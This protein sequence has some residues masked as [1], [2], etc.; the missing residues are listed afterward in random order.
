[1]LLFDFSIT[2]QAQIRRLIYGLVVPRPIAWVS[3]QSSMGID[4]LAPHSFYN[5]VSAA[6][7]ILM[8][9]SSKRENKCGLEQKDTLSNIQQTGEYVINVTTEADLEQMAV[10]STIAAP[11]VDEFDLAGLTKATSV[12]VRPPRVGSAKAAFECR[13]LQLHIVG[14]ATVVYGQAV[15][16]HVD[17]SVID[18]GRIV[19]EK[20]KP[21]ARLGGASY[22]G[23]GA[24]RSSKDKQVDSSTSQ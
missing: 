21:L 24:I 2:E 19:A 6:P 20:L 22:T 17:E 8:F 15:A 18:D 1:M 11:D 16:A 23:L 9:A 3:T 13:L 5:A 4:N 12:M 14:D 7:P 10:T